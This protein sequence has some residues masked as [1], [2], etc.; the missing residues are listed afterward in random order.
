MRLVNA[1]TDEGKALDG[2]KELAARI[3]INAR[4][5]GS[6]EENHEGI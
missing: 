6:V 1:L 4:S 3:A 2:A 5:H